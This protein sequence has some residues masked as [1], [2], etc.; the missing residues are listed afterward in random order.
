M[1]T[2]MPGAVRYEENVEFFSLLRYG[3]TK[4]EVQGADGATMPV[5]WKDPTLA[6][7]EAVAKKLALKAAT[8][9]PESGEKKAAGSLG[10]ET[11]KM[12]ED[13]DKTNGD[14]V[15]T[16]Q[17]EAPKEE[18]AAKPRPVLQQTVDA[19]KELMAVE[20]QGPT[21][22]AAEE[23]SAAP[24][25][26]DAPMSKTADAQQVVRPDCRGRLLHIR[27]SGKK[28]MKAALAASCCIASAL[29]RL[30]GCLSTDGLA[31]RWSKSSLV[32]RA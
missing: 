6:E 7:E 23:G 8:D 18:D 26:K 22:T 5:E 24:D 28:D 2:A 31:H 9:D 10:K 19:S 14:S 16:K 27:S 3:G 12:A 11:E 17:S 13:A 30:R 25:P 21:K 20:E 4:A 15:A 32:L 1:H 29:M